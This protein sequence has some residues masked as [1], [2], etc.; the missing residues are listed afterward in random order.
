MRTRVLCN[1]ESKKF[2]IRL[3]PTIPESPI[4][5]LSSRNISTAND[6]LGSG[7]DSPRL[8]KTAINNNSGSLTLKISL[9]SFP[10]NLLRFKREQRT[11]E[12]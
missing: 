6:H 5:F 7:A 3:G 9:I 2:D 8:F 1:L 10:Y 12:K 11:L 4:E